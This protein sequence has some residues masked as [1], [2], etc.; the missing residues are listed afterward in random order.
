MWAFT[1]TCDLVWNLNLVRNL[2]GGT[3]IDDTC[4]VGS[5]SLKRFYKY[6][7]I[8]SKN[9]LWQSCVYPLRMKYHP[10]SLLKSSPT[11]FIDNYKGLCWAKHDMTDKGKLNKNILMPSLDTILCLTVI[12]WRQLT[13]F[14]DNYKGLCWAKHDMTDKG[15]LNKNIL[16]P[17]LDTILCLTVIC[18]RQLCV[19]HSNMQ[20]TASCILSIDPFNL[21][22]HKN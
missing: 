8:R 5:I 19:G 7:Q 22:N 20:E 16:M 18:W 9:C 3:S 13:G 4:R 12:C 10:W 11:G 17:S 6:L 14:I 21:G 2:S 1:I 15:K